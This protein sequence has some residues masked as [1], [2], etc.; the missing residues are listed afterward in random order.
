MTKNKMGRPAVMTEARLRKLE[1]AFLFG[2]SDREAC[3]YAEIAL[4]TLYKYCKEN[5]DFSERKELLKLEPKMRA[6]I[7]LV[8]AI[9][10][11]DMKTIRWYLERKASDE[12]GSTQAVELNVTGKLD[13]EKKAHEID[14]YIQEAKKRHHLTDSTETERKE[15]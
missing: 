8:Q 1:N 4:S 5:P 10:S 2:F 6:K 15:G 11:G 12:F 14:E 13:L 7:K 9:E 3:Q